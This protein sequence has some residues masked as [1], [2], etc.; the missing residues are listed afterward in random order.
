[1][2]STHEKLTV[3]AWSLAAAAGM[4]AAKLVVGLL[5]NSLG[6]LAEALHSGLD[7]FATA[8]T[9]WAVKLAQK[10][11][12]R[13]HTYG[14][15]KF[16]N[17]SA[18]GQ[19]LLLLVTAGWVVYEAAARLFFRP[20][21]EEIHPSLSAFVVVLA[22]IFI[23]IWRSRTLRNAAV[24][25]QSQALEADALHFATDIWSS[26]VV[27]WGLFAVW[28]GHR[29]QIAW[30]IHLDAVA[31]F[32]V[33]ALVVL[34][35]IRLGLRSVAVLSDQASQELV[36]R[37][38]SAGRGVPRVL[39]IKDVRVRQ[40]GAGVFA[41]FTAVIPR[42]LS[43]EAAHALVRDVIGAVRRAVPN[44]DVVVHP[45]PTARSEEDRATTIRVLARRHGL[46]AHD[47]H[48]IHDENGRQTVELHVELD[49]ALNLRQAHERASRFEEDLKKQLSDI[50][51]VI[52][53]LEPSSASQPAEST[54][55]DQPAV[56]RLVADY[57]S[58]SGVVGHAHDYRFQH[59][60]L[61]LWLSFHVHLD[62]D[63]LI[64]EAHEISRG[65]ERQLRATFPELYR[66]TIHVEPRP[67][68]D[69][70]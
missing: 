41:D 40:S 53:H 70:A 22:C 14:H 26:L 36:A 63:L 20:E 2:H 42:E 16:E 49:P 59:T 6:M 13:N 62:G 64:P 11:P 3:A 5:T 19:T 9:L 58:G 48:S 28:L 21:V 44:A 17:L 68:E 38:A 69:D 25:Y 8:M 39:D 4:T 57:L 60:S 7:L 10:P 52:T 67:E 56:E 12:D 23:D 45:E 54:S 31:A 1:M 55:G 24:K 47:L 33:S 34:V 18:L 37:I 32:L 46:D 29:Y 66:V 65:L 27:L 35:S 30:F 51:A 43:I 15:G 61:G 50:D